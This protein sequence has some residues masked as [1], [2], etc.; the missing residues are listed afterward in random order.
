VTELRLE[1][2]PRPPLFVLEFRTGGPSFRS[3]RSGK[4]VRQARLSGML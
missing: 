3:T 4:L 1:E 2:V